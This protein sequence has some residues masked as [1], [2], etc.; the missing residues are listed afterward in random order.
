MASSS[1]C[2]EAWARQGGNEAVSEPTS[3]AATHIS[4]LVGPVAC[5]C[6]GFVVPHEHAANRDLPCCECL[7]CLGGCSA[8][9]DKIDLGA[10]HGHRHTHPLEIGCISHHQAG[11]RLKAGDVSYGHC[12]LHSPNLKTD[13]NELIAIGSLPSLVSTTW[14]QNRYPQPRL[15]ALSLALSRPPKERCMSPSRSGQRHRRSCA[16]L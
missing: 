6:D 12:H 10:Y 8:N 11:A 13:H 5:L 15:L 1:A 16:P 7:F 3:K 14:R 4:E 9:L 2:R